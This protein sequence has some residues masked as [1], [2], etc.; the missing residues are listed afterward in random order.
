MD[1]PVRLRATRLFG[2]LANETRLRII[3]LLQ[4][5]ELTVGEIAKALGILQSGAS[6]HLAILTRSGV[7][8][9]ERNGTSR[10]YRLRGPRIPRVLETIE[11]FCQVHNLYGDED[12]SL[13]DERVQWR[14]P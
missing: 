14:K 2:A 13:D 7:L 4:E 12:L 3:E 11:D 8:A 9:V 10:I 1:T 5:K 6:Q